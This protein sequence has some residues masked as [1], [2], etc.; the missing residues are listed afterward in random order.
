[1]FLFKDVDLFLV[2]SKSMKKKLIALGCVEKKIAIHGSSIDVLKYGNIQHSCNSHLFQSKKKILFVGRLIEK[3]GIIDLV[4]SV[5][6]LGDCFSLTIIGEG[7]LKEE[8]EKI[9]AEKN[10][11]SRV[12]IC[13]FMSHYKL[14]EQYS[15]YDVFV[16]P[17]KEA[18][19]GDSEGIPVVLMEAMMS[20]VPVISTVHSGISELIEDEVDG[21]LLGEVSPL[22][23]ANIIKFVCSIDNSA[24]VDRA[25]SK[26]L[27]GRDIR[28]QSNKLENFYNFL[29]SRNKITNINLEY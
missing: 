16:L 27:N 19:D 8:I 9:V 14:L 4:N 6:I 5:D 17:S 13:P 21:Y 20:K 24:L 3:K 29:I 18:K 7:K 26:I 11:K 25:K 2:R 12:K 23:L 15:K 1:M 28:I 22:S 10:L